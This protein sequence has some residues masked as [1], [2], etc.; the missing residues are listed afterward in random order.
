VASDRFD[1][2]ENPLTNTYNFGVHNHH[3]YITLSGHLFGAA[4]MICNE[5]R[6]L[7]W[8]EDVRAAVDAAARAATAYQHRL[9]AAEDDEIRKKLDPAKNEIVELTAQQREAF[10]DAVK[11]VLDRH[12]GEFDPELFEALRGS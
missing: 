1:A 8:P 3:R 5:A 4:A 12:R 7:G 9:A 11:P 6:Y 10:I 2:Q